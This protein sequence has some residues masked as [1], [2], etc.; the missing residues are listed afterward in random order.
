MKS[1]V[2]NYGVLR[3][4]LYGN[5]KGNLARYTERRTDHAVEPIQKE[6]RPPH[7]ESL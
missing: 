7:R 1:R 4:E 3:R 5:P 6:T 2:I